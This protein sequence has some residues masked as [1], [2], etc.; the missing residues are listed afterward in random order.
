MKHL[1]GIT[2][3][4]GTGFQQKEIK[5]RLTFPVMEKFIFILKG[6]L[7]HIWRFYVQLPE[8]FTFLQTSQSPSNVNY[9]LQQ[10]SEY[11]L[12]DSGLSHNNKTSKISW[13]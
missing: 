6:K 13:S 12:V 11:L 5:L 9:V 1:A 7:S 10:L 3:H 8:G 4:I 2:T